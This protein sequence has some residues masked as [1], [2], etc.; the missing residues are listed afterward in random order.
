[1]IKITVYS[2]DPFAKVVQDD[3]SVK[4]QEKIFNKNFTNMDKVVI[5]FATGLTNV[6]ASQKVKLD[7]DD[8][9]KTIKTPN[10]IF[11]EMKAF[12]ESPETNM[13]NQ[14]I[15]A[16][17]FSRFEQDLNHIVSLVRIAIG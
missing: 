3:I 5:I 7:K 9:F 17:I 4:I 15:L 14:S 16:E 12:D 6:N 8:L 2:C 1:M 13:Y 10:Q 11:I